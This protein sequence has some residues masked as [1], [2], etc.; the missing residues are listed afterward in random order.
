MD[1]GSGKIH[2]IAKDH[3][4]VTDL[5]THRT[6]LQTVKQH[7]RVERRLASPILLRRWRMKL[8]RRLRRPR[9]G[10]HGRGHEDDVRRCRLV[11]KGQKS[12]GDAHHSNAVDVHDFAHRGTR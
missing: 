1:D 9:L 11:E 7:Q 8:V 5:G 2:I 10:A 3:L 4:R 12:L 6:E